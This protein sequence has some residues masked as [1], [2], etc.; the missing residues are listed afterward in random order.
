MLLAKCTQVLATLLKSL[1][2]THNFRTATA[3]T[4]DS[5]LLARFFHDITTSSIQ[6]HGKK[7][8]ART[9]TVYARGD[10]RDFRT[11]VRTGYCWTLIRLQTPQ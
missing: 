3:A 4:N 7:V 6:P 10:S 1:D 2:Q 9:P 5:T 8:L 11:S